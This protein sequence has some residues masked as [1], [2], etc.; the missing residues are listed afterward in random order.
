MAIGKRKSTASFI[1]LVKYDAR[2][3]KATR[4]DRTQD[5]DGN[6]VTETVDITDTFEAVVDLA[7]V[8]VGWINFTAGGAPDFRMVPL[9]GDIGDAPSD[10][11]KQGFRLKLKLTNGA[12]ND[13]R[14]LASTAVALWNAID[15]LHDEYLDGVAKHKNKLPVVGIAETKQVR[16]AAGVNYAPV[17]EITS[18]LPRPP[19]LTKPARKVA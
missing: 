17:F 19:E 1:P 11:H 4:C 8:E 6:W 7:N 13:V 14:E 5:A 3:G 10:K 15:E 18:W 16:T 12:G 9:G 2:S